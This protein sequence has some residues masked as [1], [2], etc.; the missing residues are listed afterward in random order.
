MAQEELLVNYHET[1]TTEIEISLK[2][3]A[4]IKALLLEISLDN[5]SFIR[6]RGLE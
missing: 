5:V 2:T 1:Y 3:V 4:A 6:Q